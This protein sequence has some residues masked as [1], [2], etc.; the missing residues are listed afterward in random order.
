MS[1]VKLL[2]CLYICV[3]ALLN[4]PLFQNVEDRISMKL[5]VQIYYIRLS[6][7]VSG[8]LTLN[9]MS[10]CYEWILTRFCVQIYTGLRNRFCKVKGQMPRSQED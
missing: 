7:N 3:D 2:I 9:I 5:G 6:F 1:F 4:T 8:R 10:K